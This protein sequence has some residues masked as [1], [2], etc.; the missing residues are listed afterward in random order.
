MQDS[1]ASYQQDYHY[2]SQKLSEAD[3]MAN[4]YVS[5]REDIEKLNKA[6]TENNAVTLAAGI[7]CKE[8]EHHSNES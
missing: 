5:I 4:E 1:I 2:T 3:A 6:K 7:K 8:M